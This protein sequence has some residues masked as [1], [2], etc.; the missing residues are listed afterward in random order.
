[1]RFARSLLCAVLAM[2]LPARAEPAPAQVREAVDHSVPPLTKLFSGLLGAGPET[3]PEFSVDWEK[4]GD[5]G[6]RVRA[7][8]TGPARVR[9]VV[10]GDEWSNPPPQ[11]LGLLHESVASEMARLWKPSPEGAAELLGTAALLRLG[12]ATPESTARRVNAALNNCFA[13]A[14]SACLMPIQ[15]V[16]VAS[17]QRRDPAVDAFGYFRSG[18]AAMPART[19]FLDAFVVDGVRDALGVELPKPPPQVYASQVLNNLMRHDCGGRFGFWT[20]NDHLFTDEVPGCTF[21]RGGWKLRYLAG[22]DLLAQPQEAVRAAKAAC[23]RDK[24][25]AFRTL[26]ER[27]FTMPCDGSVAAVL[28]SD[29]RVA[30]LPSLR[31]ARV[32]VRQ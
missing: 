5:A 10:S 7:E 23:A 26:D 30:N 18:D 9:I 25:L 3:P 6:A 15:F 29:L 1:M 22:R 13:F 20:N 28:P 4:G 11:A 16:Q 27:E 8:R 21:F 14:G 19:G 17:A 32:L 24:A 12:L 31:I 2:A